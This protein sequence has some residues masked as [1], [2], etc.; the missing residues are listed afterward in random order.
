MSDVP[1]RRGLLRFPSLDRAGRLAL[2]TLRRFPFTLFAAFIAT[3]SALLLVDDEAS[4]LLLRLLVTAILGLPLFVALTLLVEREAWTSVGRWSV[5]AAGIL[6]LAVFFLAWPSWSEPVAFRRFAQLAIGLHL[7]VAFLPYGRRGEIDGFWQYNR[8]LFLRFLGAGVFSAVL[9]GGLA[10]ALAATDNLL[11]VQVEEETYV[12]LWVIIAFLF[13]TWFFL[14]GVPEDLDALQLRTDYPGG[15]K[16]FAQLILV[17]LVATY[18]AILM[19]YTVRILAT[20]SWPSGWIG[21]LVSSLAA[22]G[23]LSVLLVHPIRERR[24]S[25]WIRIYSRWLFAGLVPAALLLLLALWKRI[26]QYGVTENRYFLAVLG[27]WLAGLAVVFASTG[28][29]NIKAIPASLCALAFLTFFGPWSAY[30]VSEASQVGRL[31]DLLRRNGIL[32]AGR[33]GPAPADVAREDRRE[34]GAALGYLFETHGTRSIEAWFGESLARIDTI[35]TGTRPSENRSEAA[36]RAALLMEHLDLE[37]VESRGAAGT[38][39]RFSLHSELEAGSS[40]APIS[41]QEDGW[42]VRFG[43]LP[44]SATLGGRR[45]RLAYDEGSGSLVL[46]EADGRP[47]ASTPLL[48]M[49]EAARAHRPSPDRPAVPAELLR[50]V[51]EGDGVRATVYFEFLVGRRVGPSGEGGGLA[52]ESG[53]LAIEAA[54][55]WVLYRLDG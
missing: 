4:E 26:D 35:G 30:A 14:A 51:L 36:R 45:L 18:L 24:D 13:N 16:V 38:E 9:F 37:Y 55:G 53:R 23:I 46:T 47:L 54:R 52:S 29:R 22:L 12:R 31:E 7:L 11:G 48:P 39:D 28:S 10:V 50:A 1:H 21:Y 8:S 17:P 3:G 40:R 33:V 49:V 44:S 42:L 15:L 27:L 43:S 32:S 25:G 20:A 34:I 6:L 41:I 5:R 19:A 2:F